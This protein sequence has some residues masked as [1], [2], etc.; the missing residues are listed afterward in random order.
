MRI[1][2]RCQ[3]RYQQ[4][5]KR[6]L[7]DDVALES[8]E[9]PRVGTTVGRYS[10]TSVIG[11]GGLA[12]VFRA[13]LIGTQRE[14]ALKILH[15]HLRD[16]SQV[17]RMKREAQAT[18]S[19]HHANIVSVIDFGQSSHGEPF[20]AMEVL[21]GEPLDV[22]LKRV[23]MIKEA[24]AVRYGVQIARGLARAHDC[25]VVHRDIK[26]GNIFACQGRAGGDVIKLVDFGIALVAGDDRLTAA[27]SIIGSPKYLAPERVTRGE[28][29]PACDLYA[30]GL[31]LFEMISGRSPFTSETSMAFLADHVRTPP[32][33]LRQLVPS[34]SR[35]LDDL[36][37]EL[38]AKE[39]TDR[40]VDAHAVIE[41]LAALAPPQ[42]LVVDHATM[43]DSKMSTP[44]SRLADWEA[45]LV[46]LG[47][48]ARG[49]W[50][51]G[52]PPDVSGMFESTQMLLS[53]MRSVCEEAARHEVELEEME[54][55]ERDTRERFGHAIETLARD[56]SRERSKGVNKQAMARRRWRDHVH[57]ILATQDSHPDVPKRE[58][59][60]AMRE[61]ARLYQVWLEHFE[62]SRS[63]DLEAQLTA[64]RDAHAV[65]EEAFRVARDE[66]TQRL[67]RLGDQMFVVEE[68]IVDLM[69]R[70][71]ERMR[72]RPDLLRTFTLMHKRGD[73][74]TTIRT[75]NDK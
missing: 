2:P 60:M 59:L 37:D 71:Q 7:V 52:F 73:K 28:I 29:Q 63:R 44:S 12:T 14:V 57:A 16:P 25:G 47:E 39:P 34:V 67:A 49:S 56:L 58:L 3:L 72:A 33:R 15:P 18:I 5:V 23:G 24:T 45:R 19:L 22:M 4:S 43:P 53:Q 20:L 26:P 70:I 74:W 13:N 32:P 17:E 51:L 21:E 42:A 55:A 46:E 40:P 8:M 10:I 54:G 61:A 27:G 38:L 1:C 68:Q 75:R 35:K 9:N 69:Q 66:K 6:C 36:I 50:T 65:R 41:R 11:T 62:Q 31:V 48:M 64:L 30:L